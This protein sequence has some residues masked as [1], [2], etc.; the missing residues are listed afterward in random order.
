MSSPPPVV[1]T[2]EGPFTQSRI[3]VVVLA[4][5]NTM[6]V[7]VAGTV[8]EVAFLLPFTSTAVA[9]PAAGTV[10]QLIRQD[11]SW[12][13]VGR[14]VG[15][16]SNA[17]LNPSFEDSLPGTQPVNWQVADIS[18]AS[19]ATVI[20]TSDAPDGTQ[21]ARV[22]SGQASDH[23]LYSSPI[24]VNAGDIWSIAA[25]VGGDYNGGPQTADAR[26]DALWFANMT[27]L[28]PTTSSASI[29]VVTSNDVPQ[30]PPFRVVSGT[31]TAPVSGF[32]RVAL[33]S[34]LGAGQALVWDSVTARRA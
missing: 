6:F 11:S 25:F 2:L 32:M 34:T 29:N 28:F 3:G 12:V 30:Y 26:I 8:M 13:A 4:T 10:V 9:P 5:P 17:V 22:F 23:Y 24:A 33:R 27:D 19:T 20:T 18:G 7:N 31:V 21:A 15:T 1:S 16:G 14:I